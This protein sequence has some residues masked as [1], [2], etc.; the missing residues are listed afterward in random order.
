MKQIGVG[1]L[2]SPSKEDTI[3]IKTNKNQEASKAPDSAHCIVAHYN[4][5]INE[6]TSLSSYKDSWL[7][8]LVQ[9]LI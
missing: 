3:K 7:L 9:L 2:G 6:I 4:L 1:P 8:I 5:G